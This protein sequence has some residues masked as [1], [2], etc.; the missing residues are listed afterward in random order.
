MNALDLANALEEHGFTLSVADAR[1]IVKPASLLTDEDRHTIARQ[2]AAL[3]AL[4][5]ADYTHHPDGWQLCPAIPSR[6]VLIH[7]GR[8]L[9]SVCFA[10]EGET[11]D[12]MRRI[13]AG[14]PAETAWKSATAPP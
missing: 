2:R 5:S 4:Y 3:V 9:D 6:A 14:E 10:S 7:Q 8:L 12:F 1:L 11:L 13:Q